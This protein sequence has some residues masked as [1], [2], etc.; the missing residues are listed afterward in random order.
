MRTTLRGP[1]VLIIG[2]GRHRASMRARSQMQ[3]MELRLSRL[4]HLRAVGTHQYLLRPLRF[5]RTAGRPA[6]FFQIRCRTRP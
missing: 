3:R 4:R 5:V 2:H 6:L 1:S